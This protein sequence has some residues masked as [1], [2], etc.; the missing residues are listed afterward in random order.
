MEFPSQALP[1][2]CRTPIKI[3]RTVRKLITSRQPFNLFWLNLVLEKLLENSWFQ[4]FAVFWMLYAF[5]WIIPRRLNF[6]CRRFGTLCLF[7]LHLPRRKH[8][9]V[10]KCYAKLAKLLPAVVRTQPLPEVSTR[11]IYWGIKVAGAWCWPCHLHVPTI[12]KSGGL[13]HLEP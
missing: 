8:T 7:H 3:G 4:T 13:D 9:A 10:G 12:L 5:F 11:N 1:H 2:F 6:I